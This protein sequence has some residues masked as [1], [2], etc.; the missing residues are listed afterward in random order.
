M[1][2][3]FYFRVPDPAWAAV[4]EHYSFNIRINEAF[5]HDPLTNHACSPG[6]DYM[7]FHWLKFLINCFIH[8]SNGPDYQFIL[9]F[10]PLISSNLNENYGSRRRYRVKVYCFCIS[11]P[12]KSIGYTI[13]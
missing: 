5:L 10:H 12:Y 3:L 4:N 1:D 11:F 6:N 2:N 13:A 8:C 9:R 7:E